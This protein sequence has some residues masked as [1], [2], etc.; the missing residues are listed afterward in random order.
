VSAGKPTP[1]WLANFPS[2]EVR[3][4]DPRRHALIEASAGTGKTFAIE[5]LVLRL[6][7]ENPGWNPED[8]L[9]LSFTEKTAA[10]LRKRARGL[11]RLQV[12]DPAP[13][14]KGKQPIEGW[15]DEERKRLHILSMHADDLSIHTL[16]G[17]CQS[18]LRR[19]PL[20]G[21]SL[22]R[23]EVAEDRAFADDALENLLRGPWARDPERLAKL[24][25]ALDI[26]GKDS[27]RRKL[28]G[29]ALDWHPWRGDVMEPAR[30]P[31]TLEGLE[32]Q[33][34]P[35]AEA[36]R[37]AVAAV[38][39]GTF[40]PSNFR[41]S[42][43]STKTGQ[44]ELDRHAF[45]KVFGFAEDH[46]AADA[47]AILEFFRVKFTKASTVSKHGWDAA[48]P[49]A[50]KGLAEWKRLAVACEALRKLALALEEARA[51]RRL[52][53]LAEAARELRA[54]LAQEKLR[55]GVISYD[56]MPANLVVALRRNPALAA[57]IRRRYKAC[58]VDEFQDTDPVQWE[59][60]D[61]LCLRGVP[62]GTEAGG[63]SPLPL[64][65]VGDPKQAI[66]G[67][68]GGDLRT[69]L[70][71]RAAFHDMAA[72][73]RA[74]G[75]GLDA[76]F[77]SRR[78][79]VEALNAAFRHDDWFGP[80]PKTEPAPAWHLPPGS[81]DV[82]FTPARAGRHDDASEPRAFLRE[83]ARDLGIDP[84][85]AKAR[86][87]K[88]DADRAVRRWI[89]ARI[90]AMIDGGHRKPGDIAVLVRKNTEGESIERLL[91]R[92]GVPC[93]AK[94][95][96]G[97]FHGPAADALRLLLEWIGDAADPDAQARIL[98]LPFAREAAADL[99]RGRPTQCPPL[100]AKWARLS[101]DGRWPEFFDSVRREG[102]YRSRLAE[103]SPSEA[104]RFDRLAR[105]LAGSG[106]VPGTPLRS[107]R[108]RFDLLRRGESNG[109]DGS[110]ENGDDGA[111]TVMT[112]H[113]SKG[114]E[115][116]VV[117]LA[118][119]GEGSSPPHFILRDPGT[120]GFRIA[121]DK[122]DKAAKAAHDQQAHGENKRLFYVACT[123]AKDELYVPLLPAGF[124]G[125]RS[126]PLGGFAAEAFRAAAG[127]EATRALFLLDENPVSEAALQNGIAEAS[128]KSDMRA[129]SRDA[130]LDEA[131]E[132]FA[133]RRRL[134][135]YSALARRAAPALHPS[136]AVKTP[137]ERPEE[138]LGED[139]SRARREE[140]PVPAGIPDE[141]A[142]ESG[143]TAG[144]TAGELPPGA[145]AGTALHAILERTEFASALRADNPDDW[146][147][148]PGHRERVE[149]ALRRES[150]DASCA[151][152]AARAVWNALRAPIPDPFGGPPFRLAD[153]AEPDHRHEVEFLLDFAGD[154]FPGGAKRHGS[155][156]WGFIDLVFR[157]DGRYYLL[158]WKSNLLPA[159]DDGAVGR[160]MAEHR[161]DLQWKLY[162]VALDRWLGAR[163]ADYDP[164]AHFGGVVYLYLRGATP[165]R[166]AGF[167]DRP[168][169]R[170]LREEF[171]AE[172]AR[173]LGNDAEE[174]P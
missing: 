145:D 101:R 79:L 73:G 88:T 111:V 119:S 108:D 138:L 60:L 27:W 63:E 102:G 9:L 25:D 174:R 69:Y 168:T 163:L 74:Q 118:A 48:I 83:I 143:A 76:N 114:L 54:A 162:A 61:W 85:D 129:K 14:E 109:E 100:I 44:K 68:R 7:M 130:L 50:A 1:N 99:P 142:A 166:F 56:D 154:L 38:R 67:F 93:R 91:R 64:F 23:D 116:P 155:F 86:P 72:A 57:R 140:P 70:V 112:L 78:T 10:D 96:G 20:E 148:L 16:H 2:A 43:K 31:G 51:L 159:Y 15:T 66:Y 30:D 136:P 113:M 40:P 77:R 139:G 37:N 117:F 33:V 32:S 167:N 58:I 52:G 164:A 120:A 39:D 13:D 134:T 133:R 49:D 137:G 4:L 151:P 153:L 123:R 115:F 80:P 95:R 41:A 19:D 62:G 107:V 135:S 170:Q 53:L 158:D 144:I 11:L 132:A 21:N 46:P 81:E 59:I 26:S 75:F 122:E 171:P 8:I 87:K 28:V 141:P 150:V 71:A 104:E 65:L 94:R 146:L 106:S 127:A 24:R 152:A 124:K 84:S 149:E 29:L 126:G 97:V 103:Q 128:A 22:I 5:H 131:R 105:T 121:L 35:A 90:V 157:R 165:N 12:H 156:L 45:N 3:A 89:A 98:L 55:H 17:F 42:F 34:A 161:Y 47:K 125:A 169:P 18:S 92:R 36:W 172:V 173:L 147:A 110:N 6:L 82:T 160:S